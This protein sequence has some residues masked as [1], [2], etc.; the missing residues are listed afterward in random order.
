[1]PVYGAEPTGLCEPL[2]QTGTPADGADPKEVHMVLSPLSTEA[3]A[4][5]EMGRDRVAERVSTASRLCR[6]RLQPGEGLRMP[7]VE[8]VTSASG[9]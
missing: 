2:R 1:M 3:G 4:G 6:E 5:T 9:L 7:Q 8:L